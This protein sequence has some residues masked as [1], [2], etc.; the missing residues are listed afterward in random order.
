MTVVT[1][2]VCVTVLA[3]CSGPGAPA[4]VTDRPSLQACGTVTLGQGETVPDE[5]WA[6]FDAHAATGAELVVSRPTTEGDP[7]V[8][9]YRTGPGIAG[10]EVFTDTTADQ[11]GPRTWTHEMCAR[12]DGAHD[13][14]DCRTV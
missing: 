12:L 6:C 11:F 1:V 5:A 9:Y 10:V 3:A 8:T 14:A 2:L 7:I 13:P 4:A